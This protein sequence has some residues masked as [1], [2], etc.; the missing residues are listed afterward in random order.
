MKVNPVLLSRALCA[1]LVCTLSGPAWAVN[2]AQPGGNG[3]ANAAMGG[4]SIALPLDA[5]AAANN[6][7][8]L[9][10]VPTSMVVGF[11]VFRGDSSSQY[12]FQGN[13]L[14]NSTTTVGP[15]G[16]VNWQLSSQWTVGV[17]ASFGG[18]GADYGEP[19]LPVPGAAN[20]KTTLQVLELVPTVTWRPSENFAIGVGPNL[21]YERFEAQGVIVPAPVPGGLLLLPKHGQQQAS[22]VGLRM[23]ILWKPTSDLSLGATYKS[24]TTMGRLSGYEKDLLAYSGGR[25]D[26]PSQYGVGLAWR[27]TSSLTLSM[28]WLRIQWAGLKVMQDPNGFR[29]RDQ[30]IWRMGASWALDDDWTLRAGYSHSRSEI[31]SDRTLQ[32]LYVPSINKQAITAGLTRRISPSSSFNLGYEFNPK[33]TLH[34]SAGSTGTSLTSKVQMLMM[35][36]QHDF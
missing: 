22:G 18:A 23:G 8:G 2:G 7:A 26:I 35:S 4:T 3:A 20:A 36:Y 16:G 25:L 31:T 13:S 6:P 21:A 33:T 28:D 15:E 30:P 5:E 17:S 14:H 11:Q 1:S 9:A 29:W 10:F 24:R 12:V 19:A 34:G 27:A 32:N